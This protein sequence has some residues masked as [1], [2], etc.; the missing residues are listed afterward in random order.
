[1]NEA[2]NMERRYIFTDTAL[3]ETLKIMLKL[4]DSAL[5][6]NISRRLAYDDSIDLG[7]CAIPAMEQLAALE[8][9][10]RIPFFR[11]DAAAVLCRWRSGVSSLS[12]FLTGAAVLVS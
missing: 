9:K 4:P 2:L 8:T 12:V 6:T 10:A 3:Q 5:A 1:M 11:K 7:G